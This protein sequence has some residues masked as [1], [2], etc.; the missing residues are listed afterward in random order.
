MKGFVFILAFWYAGVTLAGAM[1]LPVP[2]PIIGMLLLLLFLS[3]G[4][5][6]AET[7]HKA[8]QLLLR[9]MPLF[10]VPVIAGGLVFYPVLKA[11][12]WTVAASV[13]VGTLAVLGIT[14][15]VTKAVQSARS[16]RSRKGS[17]DA[18]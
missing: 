11:Y 10:F 15:G 18:A 17:T 9:H 1:R 14:G 4:W 5:M 8:S 2:G 12:P 6:K 16:S 3:K 7:V 13:T